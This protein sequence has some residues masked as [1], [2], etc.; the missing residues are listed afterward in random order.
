M[1]RDL[2]ALQPPSRGAGLAGALPPAPRTTFSRPGA[3]ADDSGSAAP[4]HPGPSDS[5]TVSSRETD[6]RNRPVV[7]YLPAS[8]AQRLA[9]LKET[10]GHSY[11]E[12]VL[13]AFDAH[14]DL[15]EGQ[16]VTPRRSALP[17]ARTQ[18][19][20]TEDGMRTIQLRLS[21]LELRVIDKVAEEKRLNRSVL[22]SAVL[23][24]YLDTSPA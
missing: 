16:L 19:R 11:A 14:H 22:L 23:Q 8:L 17:P 1:R 18:R 3:R 20:R 13:A 21:A 24:R 9:T 7:L 6:P 15:I 2:S 4:D 10:A 5:E 12:L